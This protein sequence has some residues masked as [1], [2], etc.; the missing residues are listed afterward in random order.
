MHQA[1]CEKQRDFARSYLCQPH[2]KIISMKKKFLKKFHR[3]PRSPIPWNP[4]SQSHH[5]RRSSNYCR[6]SWSH[7]HRRHSRSYHRHHR[8][9]SHCRRRGRS[10]RRHS[11]CHAVGKNCP[12]RGRW[13]QIRPPR[14]QWCGLLP[15]HH[16]AGAATVDPPAK[17]PAHRLL[18]PHHFV[19]E[20]ERLPSIHY[21]CARPLSDGRGE[22]I[23]KWEK[24]GQP[25]LCRTAGRSVPLE[26]SW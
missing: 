21:L 7:Y 13:W 6:C 1:I 25:P 24:D 3:N 12:P 14:G 8:S 19:R 22:A 5:H 15:P 18:P 26:A 10:C 9:Q 17:G 2:A 23:G 11:N 4:S 20:V 16:F